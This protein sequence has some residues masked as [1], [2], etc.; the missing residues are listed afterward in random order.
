MFAFHSNMALLNIRSRGRMAPGAACIAAGYHIVNSGPSALS[1]SCGVGP[2]ARGGRLF[3][4]TS[5]CLDQD[6]EQEQV[7]YRRRRSLFT[8]PS[9]LDRRL[10][11]IPFIAEKADSIVLDLEDGVAMNMKKEARVK[12]AKALEK[13]DFKAAEVCV[14]VNDVQSGLL[15]DD[16][17]AVARAERLQ[18]IVVPKVSTVQDLTVVVDLLTKKYQRDDLSI[19]AAIETAEGVI[20]LRD[21]ASSHRKHLAGLIF[22][23]EDYCADVGLIRT[24]GMGEMLYARSKMVTYAKYNGLQAIDLVCIDHKDMGILEEECKNGRCMGF[25]GK[26]V[27][28]PDQLTVVNATFVPS[29]KDVAFA[30]QV[31]DLFQSASAKGEGTFVL[32][33]KVID[34]PVYKWALRILESAV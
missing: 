34:M 28:H 11:K 7:E 13:S 14:R 26:Q 32:E 17:A 20:N 22:A 24:P 2:T 8:V 3:S 19:L 21:I 5:C 16:L 9:S 33:G 18:C 10:A 25:T 15:H 29:P 30:Q 1:R 27:I 23:S 6:K 4:T 31:V 12:A